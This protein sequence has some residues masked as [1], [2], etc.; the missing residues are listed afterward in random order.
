M[1]INMLPNLIT[2]A[3]IGLS[4]LVFVLLAL[5]PL[6]GAPRVWIG[7]ATC[8][9]FI[10]A[11]TDFFD[12]WLARKLGAT[13]RLG[14]VLDPIADK[15]ALVAAAFGVC[16]LDL[17][18]ALWP[19]ALM[20]MREVFVAGLRESGVKLPVTQ[21]AKWKTTVQLSAYGLAMASQI[22]PDFR[23]YALGALWLAVI[24]TLWTGGQYLAGALRALKAR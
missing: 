9:F 3:R 10:A 17:S 7:L 21:L 14:A 2:S 5:A 23:P 11:L 16:A 20:L 1:T 22:W 8:L 24:L 6:T 4:A 12:G 19:S 18:L 15:V 13:S